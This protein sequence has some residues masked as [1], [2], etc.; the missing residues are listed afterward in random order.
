MVNDLKKGKNII[1]IN[2]QFS[3]D[4]ACIFVS[5][6]SKNTLKKH[7]KKPDAYRR[8]Q[9]GRAAD[10]E[11]ESLRISRIIFRVLIPPDS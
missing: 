10:L 8:R 1:F 9:A 5:G 11:K 4:T 7:R 3:S 2:L 6:R